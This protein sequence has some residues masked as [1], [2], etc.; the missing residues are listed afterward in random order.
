MPSAFA[1]LER[2]SGR[3][4][5]AICCWPSRVEAG[6]ILPAKA[7]SMIARCQRPIASSTTKTHV[8]TARRFEDAGLLELEVD[9]RDGLA[10]DHLAQN[11]GNCGEAQ[12]FEGPMGIDES[13]HQT[14]E[15]LVGD[16]VGAQSQGQ[17][18][19]YRGGEVVVVR[20]ECSESREDQAG[21]VE[22]VGAEEDP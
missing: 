15:Q 8:E 13:S 3:R 1:A 14:R 5:G 7:R 18:P 10:R 16:V 9:E 22:T 6:C 12:G 19:K 4:A 11:D 21:F 20:R 17:D 2:T